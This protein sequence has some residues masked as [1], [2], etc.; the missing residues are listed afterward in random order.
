MGGWHSLQGRSRADRGGPQNI[1]GLGGVRVSH[2]N[3]FSNRMTAGPGTAV[4][5]DREAAS[6][7]DLLRI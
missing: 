3:E 2:R 1:L 7:Q 5:G 4:A 6:K